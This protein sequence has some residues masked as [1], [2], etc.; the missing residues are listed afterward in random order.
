MI[1]NFGLFVTNSGGCLQAIHQR[2]Q[3]IHNHQ[4]VVCRFKRSDR[5]LAIGSNIDL[6]TKIDQPRESQLLADKVV[7]YQKDTWLPGVTSFTTG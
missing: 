1:E 4:V 5:F 6:V 2:H 7:F 3:P